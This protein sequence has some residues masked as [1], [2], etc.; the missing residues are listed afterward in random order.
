LFCALC[1]SLSA[2]V[3]KDGAEKSPHKAG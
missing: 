3:Q 1:F 2:L